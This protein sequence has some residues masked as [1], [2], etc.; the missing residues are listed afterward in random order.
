MSDDAGDVYARFEIPAQPAMVIISAD[1][2]E[3]Q[4]LGAVDEDLLDSL[5]SDALTSG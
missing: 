3:Q 1:G 4:L 5:L 2:T